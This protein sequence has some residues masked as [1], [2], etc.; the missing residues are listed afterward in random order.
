MAL[1]HVVIPVYNTK[2]YLAETVASVLNQPWK[3]ID[4]VLVNDGSNDGSADL[5]DELA[6]A[7]PRVSVIHQCNQGVSAARN[8]GIEYFLRNQVAGYVAF[9]DADDLW[10]PNVITEQTAETITDSNSADVITFGCITSNSDCSKY[11]IPLL[12]KS[13]CKD[14][15]NGVIWPML[16]T[17]C[18][19]LYSIDLLKKYQI[20]FTE[21]L[22]YCEDK[23]FKM[24]CVFLAD[25][26]S[27][28]PEILHIYRENRASA[29]HKIFSYTPMEYYLPIIDGWIA[30]DHFVNS[31]ESISGKH[32]NAGHTLASIYFGDMSAEHYQRWKSR[33]SLEAACRL[34]PHFDL[35]MNMDA[36]SV[37]KKQYARQQMHLNHPFLFIAK[38][39]II[40]AIL[41]IL[42]CALRVKPIRAFRLQRKYP[43]S[44]IPNTK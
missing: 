16:G 26:V 18:A 39:R 43:L 10:V 21:G 4:I 41:Y 25:K 3:N 6:A 14:G 23:I 33:R 20:R 44:S 2:Q 9:L 5:C 28:R 8:V 13:C 29:M 32:I 37:S 12:Y 38:N 7:E 24:Q 42:R 15:G 22:K 31:W 11:G 40:G 19:N 27:F 30:S 17:F 1:I 35:Y 36:A 34:H